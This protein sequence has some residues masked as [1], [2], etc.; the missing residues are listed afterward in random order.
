MAKQF[1]DFLYTSDFYIAVEAMIKKDHD[2]NGKM[3]KVWLESLRATPADTENDYP[4]YRYYA[5]SLALSR[6]HGSV[7][8]YG[9]IT[10]EAVYQYLK[11]FYKG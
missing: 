2:L 11:D 5:I 10:V 7:R 6:I 8:Q 3:G 1:D 4:S 9:T